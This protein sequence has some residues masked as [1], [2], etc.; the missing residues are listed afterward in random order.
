MEHLSDTNNTEFSDLLIPSP[1]HTEPEDDDCGL[2]EDPIF[3]NYS[4]YL[5]KGHSENPR[6][7]KNAR[8]PENN[9]GY[10]NLK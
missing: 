1:E 2:P 10:K 3:S 6:I 4:K 5:W 9:D 7:R 8:L